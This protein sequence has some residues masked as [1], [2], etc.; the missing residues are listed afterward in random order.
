MT[1]GRR[2]YGT[3]DFDILVG[4]EKDMEF[5]KPG[6]V[7][8]YIAELPLLGES[9]ETLPVETLSFLYT[10]KIGKDAE[11]EVKLTELKTTKYNE[12]DINGLFGT[13]VAEGKDDKGS[14]G[15]AVYVKSGDF[16]VTATAVSTRDYTNINYFEYDVPYAANV[17]LSFN[18]N[19]YT[20][21]FGMSPDDMAKTGIIGYVP[22]A[23]VYPGGA[24]IL[25]SMNMTDDIIQNLR[26]EYE[27]GNSEPVEI[28]LNY[29]QDRLGQPIP[30]V[31][32]SK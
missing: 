29:L 28:S 18:G 32:Y 6:Y 19:V 22:S 27:V 14:E 25:C 3:G 17:S 15:V 24:V 5:E 8:D 13:C 31:I 21:A 20:G 7:D 4:E 2:D 26:R 16:G 10:V 11:E 12:S 30:A 1:D 9:I 23:T